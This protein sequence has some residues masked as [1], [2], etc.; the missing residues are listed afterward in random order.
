MAWIWLYL[1]NISGIVGYV[2][3]CLF[4]LVIPQLQF[5][6]AKDKE[7]YYKGEVQEEA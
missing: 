5:A 6:K 2:L 4:L 1:Q 3:V 7:K